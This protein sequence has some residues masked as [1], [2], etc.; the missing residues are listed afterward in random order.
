MKAIGYREWR[1]ATEPDALIE[2]DLPRPK[3]LARDLLVRV[4]AISV[5]PVD[6]KMRKRAA[7]E[8]GGVRV[9]GYDAAGIVEVVG[10]ACRFF[11][12]GDAVF[13]AGDIRRPGT[14]AEF[15]LVDERIVGRK[16]ARLSFAEAAA[17]PL[18]SITAWE[19]LFDRLDARREG[20][21]GKSLLIIGAAGGVGS[22]LIQ[23]AR[24]LTHLTVI[25]TA[26][27]PETKAWC[28]SLGAHHV[29]DHLG[30]LVAQVSALGASP[31]GY[32]ASL[33]QTDTHFT[34]IAE[35]VAPQGRVAL[36]DDPGPIDVRL[37]KT[38]SASLHWEL[39]FTRSM[40]ETPDM[41]AQHH[42]LN[43]VSDLVDQGILKT[44]V[45]ENFGQITA[46]NLIRAHA[47]LESG[48]ARGK[49]VLAGY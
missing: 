17:L 27:R 28:L 32:V 40:F 49:I 22:I 30:D 35:L 2:I 8:P 37:L 44:T 45:G 5:N 34:A 6:F 48:K 20:C 36:I 24:K 46:A 9:L 1:P 23:L 43:E 31:V 47:V 25:A 14:N 21:K 19:L 33:T 11:K 38:K 10:E 16:P 29:I 7:P 42:L 4:E 26:S 12:P 18:T 15:H 41:D 3:P 39:M 13:Y